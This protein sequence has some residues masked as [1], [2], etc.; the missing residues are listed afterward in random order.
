MLLLVLLAVT[1]PEMPTQNLL[2]LLYTGGG[3]LMLLLPPEVRLPRAWP[4]LVAGFVIFSAAGL[5]PREWFHALPWRLDLEALGLDTGRH[6]FVQ[7]QLAAESWA[8]FTATALVGLYLLGHRIDSRQHHRLALGFV[9]G[10]A[11][12]TTAALLMQKPGGLFGFFPNRNHTATLLVMATFV[13]LGSLTQAIRMRHAWKIFLSGIPICLF[14]WALFTVSESRAGVVL[15]AAGFVVWVALAGVHHLRGQVGKAMVLLLIG[16]G[17]IFIVVDSKV[18]TRLD[19]TIGRIDTSSP[20]AGAARISFEESPGPRP[21]SNIDGRI[22][23]F[24]DTWNMIRHENWTGVGPG[25]FALVFPQYRNFTS[26]ANQARCL[27]PES[28]WLMMLAEAGWPAALCLAAG[29]AAVFVAATQATRL[30]RTRF[31]RLGCLVAALVLCLHGIFDVPG[32]RIGLAWSAALL[33]SMSLR[34]PVRESHNLP[35]SSR[36]S[37]WSWRALGL[38]LLVAGVGLLHAQWTGTPRL[39]SVVVNRLMQEAKALYDADQA[40]YDLAKAEGR[41]Y[42]PPPAEDRL[43]AA[44][45]RTAQVIRVEPLAPHPHF[46]RGALALH[47]DDKS[48]I[49]IQAFA[50]QRRL[51]P[52]WVELPLDQARAWMDQDSQQTLALWTEAMQRAAAEEARFPNSP[53]GTTHTY[54][55]V[56]QAAGKDETLAAT[57]FHLAGK[58]P[59]LLALWTRSAPG[60]LLDREMPRLLLSLAEPNHRLPLFRDWQQ[61]G[62]QEIA[63]SFAKSHPELGLLPR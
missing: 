7:P 52:T 24:R 34:A 48:A 32:H 21:D 20:P 8:G 47:F 55:N 11:V 50:I 54:Q 12:W 62:S 38:V 19:E 39:P 36:W 61:R 6:A 59:A 9:L 4:M 31:L 14:L 63:V 5:L 60:G 13:S 40:A 44:L 1:F 26:A 28:D 51:V 16:I 46:I 10:V 25:Q 57:A 49:A 18:K 56:L 42:Q 23:I 27:H 30:G 29:V 2:G 53:V 45:E 17:G 33:L 43:E 37:R 3:L 15:T 41:D 58:N 22:A 35:E